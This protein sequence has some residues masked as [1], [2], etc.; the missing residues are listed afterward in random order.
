VGLGR[1]LT[2]SSGLVLGGKWLGNHAL[3]LKLLDRWGHWV[4]PFV[5][6]ALDS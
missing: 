2:V 1:L 3:A 5:L 4:V 6:I